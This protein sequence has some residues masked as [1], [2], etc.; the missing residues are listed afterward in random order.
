MNVYKMSRLEL[1]EALLAQTSK[2]KQLKIQ[3]DH[4]QKELDTL[5]EEYLKLGHVCLEMRQIAQSIIMVGTNG[6]D[7]ILQTA[8]LG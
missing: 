4:Y 2:A 1:E 8:P 6:K 7:S 5:H 3:R